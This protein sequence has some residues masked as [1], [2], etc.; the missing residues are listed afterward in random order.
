MWFAFGLV[1][2][3]V[4][5]V[6]VLVIR[7]EI[8]WSG[9]RDGDFEYSVTG[10]KHSDA[11]KMAVAAPAYLELSVHP[12]R[13]IDR[14]ATAIGLSVEQQLDDPDTDARIYL[15]SD[16]ARVR[17]CLAADA[18]ARK[19]LLDIIGWQGAKRM[20]VVGG[21]LIV[22]L[23][24]N[25]GEGKAMAAT[26]SVALVPKMRCVAKALRSIPAMPPGARD[27]FAWRATLL[28]ALS[29]GIFATALLE[30]FAL[31]M[32]LPGHVFDPVRLLVPGTLIGLAI[33]AG[34]VCLA[35]YMLGRR[36]RTHIVL[37]ELLT[38][39]LAGS[40][41]LSYVKL[42]EFNQEFDGSQPVTVEASIA[43][44]R[45]Y[46]CGR[47]NRRTCYEVRFSSADGNIDGESMRVS[48]TV[49]S[50]TERDDVW[51]LRMRAG[52]LHVPWL[53]SWSE[54]VTY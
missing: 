23:T 16:D 19:A 38:L 1:A 13:A 11:I 2:L 52:A 35:L 8:L 42:H 47:R 53:E 12:E 54:A 36:S 45:T 48:A 22:Y 21:R 18:D 30:Y 14:F 49:Y 9:T 20:R 41:L 4:A 50:R 6:A 34:M 26:A 24:C 28:L 43:G 39:G 17:D 51:L 5:L 33:T 31:D 25:S 37:M 15:Q 27:P 40:I 29:T 32:L 44:K 46:K 10:G 7:R 3:L